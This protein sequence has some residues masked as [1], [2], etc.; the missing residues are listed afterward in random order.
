MA[1]Y[2]VTITN[3]DLC[4]LGGVHVRRNYVA[5]AKRTLAA[6]DVSGIS[7]LEATGNLDLSGIR[8]FDLPAPIPNYILLHSEIYSVT[9][10]S[11]EEIRFD[12]PG[13]S[14]GSVTCIVLRGDL[15]L[16]GVEYRFV[17]CSRVVRF[18]EENPYLVSWL[19]EALTPLQTYLPGASLF[20]GVV[21]DPDALKGDELIVTA[22]RDWTVEEALDALNTFDDAWWLDNIQCAADKVTFT[23]EHE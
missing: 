20:L 5:I 11:S 6:V 1:A 3:Q 16:L 21:N 14:A 12:D 4:A 22:R 18:L 13:Y 23:V 2:K 10:T 17:D 7:V 19:L 8:S 9:S 15:D